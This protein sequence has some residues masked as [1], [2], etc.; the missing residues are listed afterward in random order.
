M[1]AAPP[2]TTATF[3]SRRPG[4]SNLPPWTRRRSLPQCNIRGR[5]GLVGGLYVPPGRKSFPGAGDC[6]VGVVFGGG[7]QALRYVFG[8]R[9]DYVEQLGYLRYE[10]FYELALLLFFGVP[11]HA[12]HEGAG[13]VFD[14]LDRIVF[15]AAGHD[16]SVPDLPNALMVVGLDRRPLGSSGSGGERA[17]FEVYFMVGE[18]A[19]AGYKDPSVRRLQ[20][21]GYRYFS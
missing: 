13:R 12:E 9:V 11:E 1:P 5:A 16:E 21:S 2:V 20:A 17:R 7:A 6:P 4:I 19:R 15:G 14:G 10:G 18:G 3:P 8:G